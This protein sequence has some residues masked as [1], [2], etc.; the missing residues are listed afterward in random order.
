MSGLK[1]EHFANDSLSGP[2]A[3]QG[4]SGVSIDD[5]TSAWSRRPPP[6]FSARWSGYLVVPR[7]GPYTFALTSDD[8]STLRIDDQLVVDNSGHHATQTKS[9]Q[10][11]LTRGAH[12]VIVE[13]LQAGGAY[14]L[15]WQWAHDRDPLR[16]V[17][18]SALSP[19]RIGYGTKLLIRI[20]DVS[21]LPALAGFG[22]VVV[23]IAFPPASRVPKRPAGG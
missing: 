15:D 23:W 4:L 9:G 8:G 18:E 11:V 16:P 3:M 17:P 7:T 19:Y 5:I 12:P 2:P 10:A 22:A 13:Y 20:V 14:D 6:A 21:F 1:V